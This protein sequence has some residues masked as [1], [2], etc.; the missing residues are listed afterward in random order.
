MVVDL[1]NF[2]A[3]RG[4]TAYGYD[5]DI[6][7]QALAYMKYDVI[8]LGDQ[9]VAFGLDDLETL[10]GPYGLDL[11]NN[12]LMDG[13]TGKYRF[14][15]YKIVK[16]GR[17]KVGITSTIG[18]TAVIHRTLREKEG[19]TVT[20]PI[21]ASRE[22][23]KKLRKEG[24]DLTVL[25]AHTGLREA[26]ILA[27][28]IPGYDVILVGH[29]ARS[30]EEPLK[31]SGAILAGTRARSDW[32][33][34]LT[35][36]VE[37]KQV[38]SFEGTSFDM[39]QDD[40]PFD[41]YLREL[42]WTKLDLDEKGDR[43]RKKRG[44]EEKTSAADR[45]DRAI[46]ARYLGGETCA[47]CHAE[48]YNHWLGTAHARAFETLATGDDDDWNNPRCWNCHVVAF[49]QPGGHPRDELEPRL[50]NVQCEA[51]HGMG[52]EHARGEER[53]KVGEKVC[54]RC[55]VKKWS[56]DFDY[57]KYASKIVCTSTKSHGSS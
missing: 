33:G 45:K 23:L 13:E 55:H 10:V 6:S 46:E 48:I 40:G 31:R 21:E 47:N 19:V 24:V 28:S 30:L 17:A 7:L 49:G 51:C 9:E 37:K 25:L 26:E 50:W 12:N 8:A 35:V 4:R 52:T 27:D 56:P 2:L 11:V 39:R 15:P 44:E 18:G 3:R 42:T 32:L 16:A 14:A 41:P 5:N 53:E 34:D 38:R 43:I 54:L 36:V 22:A 20:N 57:E 1:G 29:G